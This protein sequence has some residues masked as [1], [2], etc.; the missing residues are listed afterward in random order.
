MKGKPGVLTSSNLNTT[1]PHSRWT[2]KPYREELPMLRDVSLVS[3]H[4]LHVVFQD[5]RH[6]LSSLVA[7]HL[8]DGTDLPFGH[9]AGIG[10]A[11]TAQETTP[12]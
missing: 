4:Y 11:H 8:H 7:F 10:I 9:E 1:D 5:T 3:H 12:L 2:E 6:G